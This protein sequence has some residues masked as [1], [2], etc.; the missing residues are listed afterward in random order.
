[1]IQRFCKG[2][3]DRKDV[4]AQRD[5]EQTTHEAYSNST[6]EGISKKLG[7][8]N[9][10]DPTVTSFLERGPTRLHRPKKVIR[11]HGGNEIGIYEG[12]WA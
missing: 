5:A 1:M 10:K 11:M 7:I 12:E 9:E 8:Y 2:Y 3:L 6:I 4:Q